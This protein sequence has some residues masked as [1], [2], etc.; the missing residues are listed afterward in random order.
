MAVLKIKE[1]DI[2]NGPGVSVSV[3]FA[4]CP[5]RCAGC[6]NPDTWDPNQGLEVDRPMINHI[7]KKLGEN[8]VERNLVI[9]GGE[10]LSL[11]NVFSL[12][13]LLEEVRKEVPNVKVIIWTGYEM[14]DIRNN[15]IQNYACSFA[16]IVIDGKFK[17][18][19]AGVYPY[20]GSK[21]QR[22]W[23]NFVDITEKVD[24]LE[25]DLFDQRRR[26]L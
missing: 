19:E 8:G 11:E 22:I 9:L 15:Y 26:Q 24:A 23:K 16:N 7:I 10:P 18:D 20:R 4:G 13:F 14:E 1:N 6:H 21:N 2:A 3:W 12:G 17:V 25:I 5:H